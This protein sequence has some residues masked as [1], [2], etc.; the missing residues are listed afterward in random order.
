MPDG[1]DR[2]LAQLSPIA[3]DPAWDARVRQSCHA[4]IAKRR[5]RR[6]AAERPARAG[7]LD[8]AAAATL[9]VYLVAILTAVS[10]LSR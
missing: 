1:V 9:C 7:L 10:R 2:L 3:P 6:Q 5:S 8:I 4:A